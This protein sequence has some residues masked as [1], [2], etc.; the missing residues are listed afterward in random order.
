MDDTPDVTFGELPPERPP[1]VSDKHQPI[2]EAL[3]ERPGEWALVRRGLSTATAARSR[4][5]LQQ[6]GALAVTRSSADGEGLRDVW[7]R[8]P[9]GSS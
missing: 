2:V 6:L 5:R 7:A 1:G 8:W 4:S 9:E 3:K